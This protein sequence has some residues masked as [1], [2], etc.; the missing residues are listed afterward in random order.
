MFEK[1]FEGG[2]HLIGYPQRIISLA[3]VMKNAPKTPLMAPLA[4]IRGAEESGSMSM[5]ARQAVIPAVK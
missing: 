4:P 5:W 2:A 1:H 3:Q